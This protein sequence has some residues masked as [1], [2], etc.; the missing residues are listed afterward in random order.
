MN[1]ET[2]HGIFAVAQY[3]DPGLEEYRNNPL[4]STLPA[5]MEQPQVVTKL[6]TLPKIDDSEINLR[7]GVRVHAIARILNDFFQ[8]LS[9]HIQL[10]TKLSLLIRQGYLGRNPASG[11]FYTHLQNGYERIVQQDLEATQTYRADSTATSL[12]LFG[13]SGCGKTT[14]LNRIFN[15]YDQVL[16]HSQYNITQV[17]YLK[18]DCSHD[19]TLKGLCINFFKSLDKVAHTGYYKKYGQKR[20]SISLML[21]QMSQLASIHAIGVIVIDEI[22]HLNEAKSGGAEKMLNFFVTLVNTIG[23]PVI[24]VGTPKARYLFEGDLRS[25]RRITGMGSLLWDRLEQDKMWD[26]FLKKMWKYQWLEKATA[27]DAD[28]IHTM[29]DL[30]QGIIDIA[31]KLFVLAQ[32]R[33]I[34][35]NSETISVGLL[36]SVYKDEFKPVHP[37]V[38]ALRSRRPEQIAK[39]SD[40]HM[41]DVTNKLLQVTQVVNEQIPN[42]KPVLP[43]DDKAKPLVSLLTQM[44]IAM[45]VAIPLVDDILDKYP[46]LP[47]GAVIHKLTK[48]MVKKE[49]PKPKVKI[50]KKG[51]WES[52]TP[53]DLRNI[54]ALK[55]KR[56]FYDS[57]KK[58][59]VIFGLET[60]LQQSN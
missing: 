50:I 42:E 27:L 40:L 25:A 28:L 48:H 21:A 37:M 9:I 56:S 33:A 41:P 51:Q 5:I 22:Q 15:T 14:A 44:N 59:S 2:P 7:K 49:Q 19:G 10:E 45:D 39:Y 1:E 58:K 35:T 8:P 54:Y 31:V 12:S 46:D 34:V 6:R 4:I 52:L 13:C 11:T 20:L 29:Y 57:A 36:H 32:H 17:V 3:G 26:A 53:E 24:L 55:G 23:V 30:S 43:T 47:V 18:V 16:F 60:I 38:N